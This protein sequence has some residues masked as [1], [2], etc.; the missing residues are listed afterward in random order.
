MRSFILSWCYS[1][2]NLVSDQEMLID[3][4]FKADSD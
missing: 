2:I 3:K 1:E 4:R